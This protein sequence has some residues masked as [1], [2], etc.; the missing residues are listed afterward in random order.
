VAQVFKLNKREAIKTGEGQNKLSLAS[1]LDISVRKIEKYNELGSGDELYPG[2]VIFLEKKRNRAAK[3]ND[4]HTVK[5]GETV[6]SIAQQY[7]IKVKALLK[8]N[9]MWFGSRLEPGQVL[10][11]RKRKGGRLLF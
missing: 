8:K 1:A 5:V 3:G 4:F 9:N 7:G 11:L 2:Q 10:N 6:Y